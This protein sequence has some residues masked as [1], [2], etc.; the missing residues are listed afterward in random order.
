MVIHRASCMR[1]QHGKV[2]QLILFQFPN[3]P[4]MACTVSSQPRV[5]PS[6]VVEAV[7][8]H[9]LDLL[10]EALACPGVDVDHRDFS[11][12]TGLYVAVALGL[13][14]VVDMLVAAGADPNTPCVSGQ[15]PVW[16][17]A[18]SG[19]VPMLRTLLRAGGDANIRDAHG[20]CALKAL[21]CYGLGLPSDVEARV[22]ELVAHPHT[23]LDVRDSAGLTAEDAAR[24]K[25]NH[26]LASII[27]DEVGAG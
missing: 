6:S 24:A 13:P 16:R 11:G 25:G 5:V 7:K 17:A 10:E 21:A 1:R 14:A 4:T 20:E 23:A 9:R 15:T 26:A 19:S 2:Q 12:N 3:P 8:F 18:V 27:A 22:R